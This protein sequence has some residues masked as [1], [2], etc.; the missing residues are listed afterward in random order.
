MENLGETVYKTLDL[1]G[2]SPSRRKSAL[3]QLASHYC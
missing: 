2:P 3:H 1:E